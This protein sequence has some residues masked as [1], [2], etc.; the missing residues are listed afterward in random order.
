[1]T[2]LEFLPHVSMSATQ[3]RLLSRLVEK[4][5]NVVTHAEL[6]SL[7]PS[8]SVSALNMALFA[9]RKKIEPEGYTIVPHRGLGYSLAEASAKS[10]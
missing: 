2:E 10:A 7:W 4:R 8:R 5:P 6:L 1:M 9:V 3:R